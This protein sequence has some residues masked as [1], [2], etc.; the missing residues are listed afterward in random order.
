[1]E[2]Y[3]QKGFLIA[4]G[5]LFLKSE[6]VKNL[7]KKRLV[8]NLSFFLKR[9]NIKGSLRLLR[10]RIFF[11]T[12]EN[13]KVSK[14][15]KCV[16]G[17]SW[18]AE[19][20]FFKEPS[21]SGLT[22]YIA[23]NYKEW[24][25]EDE[26]FALRVKLEKGLLKESREEVVAKLARRIDRKVNLSRPKKEIF[27]EWRKSGCFIYFNKKKGMGGL[28]TAVSGKVLCLIS[29]GI[30]SPVASFLMLKRGAESIWLHFHSFPLLSKTSQE[31]VRE[32]ARIFL[33]YQSRLKIYFV[34]FGEIQTV[35]RMNVTSK[36]RI[37]FY[38]CLMFKIAEKI[39]EKEKCLAIVTGE[40]L[41]QVS[42]Q[43][44]PNLM[45]AQEGIK[46]PILRPLIG[47]DK[48]EIIRLAKKIKTFSISIKPQDDCCTLFVPRHPTAEG[49]I[50][51]VKKLAQKLNASHLIRKA[52][53]GVEVEFY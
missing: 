12:E 36:Y 3:P 30:D 26:E 2:K 41:G 13:K 18:F 42:S 22:D 19:S 39:A 46:F 21:L 49:K 34:P 37:L 51:V 35:I 23:K 31:K 24:I 11:E 27:I 50:E 9:E 16:S 52:L 38:R 25:K 43:T 45:I 14:I 4:F 32:L 40:S 28:P 53:K 47:M 20:F 17:I 5:E 10:E 7:F 29:G 8:S 6:R 1:M 15:L 44:L 33:K 48:E